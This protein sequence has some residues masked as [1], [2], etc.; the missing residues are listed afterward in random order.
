MA[1]FNS[2][3]KQNIFD[4]V[5]QLYGTLDNVVEF[6]VDNDIGLNDKINANTQLSYS[7]GSD[8]GLYNIKNAIAR[9]EITLNNYA[10]PLVGVWILASNIWDDDG[11]WIDTETWND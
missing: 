1:I 9:K 11:E 3:Y 10:I 5:V 4:I 2:K 7:D 6:A 8:D